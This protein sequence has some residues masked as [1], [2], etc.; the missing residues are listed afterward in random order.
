L[1]TTPKWFY[2]AI[3]HGENNKNFNEIFSH[4]EVGCT[5]QREIW[6]AVIPI[7]QKMLMA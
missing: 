3:S 2:T 1:P 5:E 7:R 4:L 6:F